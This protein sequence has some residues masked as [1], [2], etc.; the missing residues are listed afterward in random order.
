MGS[1]KAPRQWFKRLQYIIIQFGSVTSMCDSFLFVYKTASHIV[2]LLVYVDDIIL[3]GSFAQ[4]IQHLTS[5]LNSKFSI[6]QLRQLD[7]FLGI[8]VK[9]L[10]NKSLILTRRKHIRD[11]LQKTNMAEA[12]PIS[13]PMA[14]SCK[15][16]WAQIYFLILLYIGLQ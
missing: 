1:N 16:K 3:I 9:T 11:L 8:E 2:Y 12:K 13:S 10:P 15:L 14:S 7:Y 5:Q 6:K 4:M